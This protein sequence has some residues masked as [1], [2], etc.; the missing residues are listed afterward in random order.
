MK[1]KRRLPLVLALLLLLTLLPARATG[2][3]RANTLAAGGQ[4]HSLAVQEDGTVL[5]WGDNSAGQLGL[6]GDVAE[7]RKPTAVEGVSAVSVAAG[8]DFSAALRYDGAVYTWGHGVHAAPVQAAI[9]QVAAIA[10]GGE[11][12]LALKTDGTV[13][14]W[15]YGGAI[16]RVSGLSR[17]AAI[18]TG[19]GHH[20][21]LTVRGEVWAWGKNDRGQS[22]DGTAV[23]RTAPFADVLVSIT[24]WPAVRLAFLA[25]AF[26]GA[27]GV[28][29]STLYS[30]S[31][32]L[33]GLARSKLVPGGFGRLHP[34]YG[35]PTR[36]VWFAAAFVLPAPFTGKLFF[37]PL[38]HVASLATIVMWV[39][40][41]A[42]VLRLRRTRSDLPRP[43]RM[44]GGRPM[45][46]FGV[47]AALF[48]AGNI[49]LPFSPGAL[50]PLE[51]L[52]ALGLTALGSG[53]YRLRDRS[54][55][56][57]E[58]EALILGYGRKEV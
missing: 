4:A 26:V 47:L 6:G 5:V 41:L 57:Q 18:A 30:S 52:L 7:I 36:C 53:L 29:N 55:T 42:A 51:Y 20:L 13:W 45:A 10:A 54:L 39:M 50:T 22:G 28:M 46:A 43:V 14:Q 27:V 35:T 9:D 16:S 15:T 34:R 32:M 2:T 33:Y 1:G 40:T 44:P 58:R 19:G 11:V 37:R 56:R 49:L 48:L 17:V 23:D 21:A 8:E 31:R 25:T 12:V 38:I 3:D 24:G